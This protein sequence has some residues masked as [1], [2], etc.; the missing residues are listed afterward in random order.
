VSGDGRSRER[1]AGNRQRSEQRAAAHRSVPTAVA[2]VRL[3]LPLSACCSEFTPEGKRV[4]KLDSILLNGNNIA[5][6]RVDSTIAAGSVWTAAARR[7]AHP[8]PRSLGWM[9]HSSRICWLL[10]FACA[11]LL[12]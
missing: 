1:E 3:L 9:A 4:T 7:A 5:I 10:C 12:T 2:A 11:V 8:P 6:V